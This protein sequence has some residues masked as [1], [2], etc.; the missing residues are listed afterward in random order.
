MKKA[1]CTLALLACGS[2]LAQVQTYI[3]T[4]DEFA[5]VVEVFDDVAI[6]GLA[7]TTTLYVLDGEVLDIDRTIPTYRVIYE[8]AGVD[9][10]GTL[11]MFRSQTVYSSNGTISS[12]NAYEVSVAIR[13]T[14]MFESGY[15][16]PDVEL[17]IQQS[18]NGKL[19][20]ALAN[21]D[22][23]SIFAE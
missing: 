15:R 19:S 3:H 16:G 4:T 6:G 11:S 8:H 21:A 17:D 9:V 12:E 14:L 13:E 20:I 18:R 23:F 7:F 5:Y 1:F 2:S 22:V 10:H